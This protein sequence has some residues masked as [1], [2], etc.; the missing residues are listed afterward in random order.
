MLVPIPPHNFGK[1]VGALLGVV[2]KVLALPTR[3]CMTWH[4]GWF[5]VCCVFFFFFLCFFFFF[6]RLG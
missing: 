4:W 1:K 3:F 6:E 2:P 5:Y